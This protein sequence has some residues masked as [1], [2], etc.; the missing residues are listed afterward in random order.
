MNINYFVILQFL[1]V[2]VL[3]TYANAI[4]KYEES[5]K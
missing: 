4:P 3:L 1:A 2:M 5:H